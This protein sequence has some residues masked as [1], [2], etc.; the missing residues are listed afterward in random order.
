MSFDHS[1]NA[2]I[3]FASSFDSSDISIIWSLEQKLNVF[4]SIYLTFRGI[5]KIY[6][7]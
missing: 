2:D 6:I 3:D 5:K 1:L 4:S 7:W